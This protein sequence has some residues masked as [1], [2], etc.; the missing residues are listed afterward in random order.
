MR[1]NF[2]FGMLAVCLGVASTAVVGC[3]NNVLLRRDNSSRPDWHSVS[4]QC[5]AQPDGI[6]QFNLKSRGVNSIDELRVW[7]TSNSELLWVV[8]IMRR[9]AE[10]KTIAY[11]VLPQVPERYG[12]WKIKQLF[13]PNGSP[14]AISPGETF[15]VKVEFQYDTPAPCV[16]S[17]CFVFQMQVDGSVKALPTPSDVKEPSEQ[18]S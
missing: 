3:L 13:P 9:P 8:R 4:L 17:K 6:L 7:S 12:V 1:R 18:D 5:S 10:V 14:R 11:G 16:G 15:V 2:V